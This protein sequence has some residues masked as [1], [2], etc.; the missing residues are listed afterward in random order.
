MLNM[1]VL[2]FEKSCAYIK[3][4]VDIQT[5]NKHLLLEIIAN[6]GLILEK[7][8]ESQDTTNYRNVITIANSLLETASDNIT[9]LEQLNL[10]VGAITKELTDVLMYQN[11]NSKSKQYY[12]VTFSNLKRKIVDYTE[13]FKSVQAKVER[14]N[15]KINEFINVNNFK[16]NVNPVDGE[17]GLSFDMSSFEY[18]GYSVDNESGDVNEIS[19]N[20]E[21][22]V[23][24]KTVEPTSPLVSEE[25]MSKS[26]E[27]KIN[28]LANDF[29]SILTNISEG[30][31][32]NNPTEFFNDYFQKL[33]SDSNISTESAND[34]LHIATDEAKDEEENYTSDNEVVNSLVE[35]IKYP[36]EEESEEIVQEEDSINIVEKDPF[37]IEKDMEDLNEYIAM[38]QDLSEKNAPEEINLEDVSSSVENISDYFQSVDESEIE[39]LEIFRDLYKKVIPDIES[40]E[41][42]LNDIVIDEDDDEDDDF[43]STGLIDEEIEKINS[44]EIDRLLDEMTEL[45]KADGTT[46]VI[47]DTPDESFDRSFAMSDA[48][49]EFDYSSSDDGFDNSMNI[50]YNEEIEESEI[51]QNDII[52][53]TPSTPTFIDVPEKNYISL[54]L[55]DDMDL[56]SPEESVES[57]EEDTVVPDDSPIFDDELPNI[58]DTLSEEEIAKQNQ[59]IINVMDSILSMDTNLTEDI[60]DENKPV[61]EP[62]SEADEANIDEELLNEL[63]DMTDFSEEESILQEQ[64]EVSEPVETTSAPIIANALDTTELAIDFDTKIEKIKSAEADNET[65]IFSKTDGHIYLPYKIVELITYLENYPDIYK[66]LRDVVESEFILPIDYF[67]KNLEKSRYDEAYNLYRNKAGYSKIEAFKIANKIRKIS[68]LNPAIIAACR[69]VEELDKYIYFLKSNEVEKFKSFNIVYIG[70]ND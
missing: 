36:T 58:K 40:V 53:S 59:D 62:V 28:E 26:T 23:E 68:N 19:E 3:N 70:Y 35:D 22:I 42:N 37:D 56:V 46:V 10:E 48:F 43:N 64:E 33:S 16:F 32:S 51:I 1:P 27:E 38:I 44:A 24:G 39:N 25:F 14:D 17:S 9:V 61:E 12:I 4:Q 20:S 11:K 15:Q 41:I 55:N 47:D 57:V 7:T 49:D 50:P 65:L 69:S 45:E 13:R 54:D 60:V 21:N 29:K 18:G 5:N 31:L 67:S 63:M 30:N 6:I 66:S 2:K 8:D 52:T 34:I